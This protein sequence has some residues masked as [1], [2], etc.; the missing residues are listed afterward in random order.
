MP[1]PVELEVISPIQSTITSTHQATA[2][3]QLN[4]ALSPVALLGDSF[5]GL[6][7]PICH[8]SPAIFPVPVS[9]G[10]WAKAL[11]S[12]CLTSIENKGLASRLCLASPV[13]LKTGFE[14]VRIAPR[15]FKSP[16][17][18][19]SPLQRILYPSAARKASPEQ[20][21]RLDRLTDSSSKSPNIPANELKNSAVYQKIRSETNRI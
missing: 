2:L 5:K 9:F 12:A 21:M 11:Y 8:Q 13:M 18:A 7:R 1:H 16:A 10:A 6:L 17:S 3:A 15:D 20:L 14:P 4:K 19:I